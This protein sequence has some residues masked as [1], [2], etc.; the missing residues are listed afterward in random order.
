MGPRNKAYIKSNDK[1]EFSRDI[2]Q[3]YTAPNKEA[4]LTLLNDFALKW[5]SKYSYAVKSWKNKWDELTV[6]FDYPVEIRKM[7]YTTNLIEN[8]NDKIRKYA[9]NKLS[10]STDD[11]V[12]K[13]VFLT[14]REASKKWT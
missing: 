4:A 12:I 2:K 1:K 10:Y 3:S 5:E 11:V 8:L 13:S 9:K 7:I 6:F 14:I